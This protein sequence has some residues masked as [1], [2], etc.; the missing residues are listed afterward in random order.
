[1]ILGRTFCNLKNVWLRKI[2]ISDKGRASFD[3]MSHSYLL[4]EINQENY[5]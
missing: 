3:V 2:E 1:M 5:F 4:D